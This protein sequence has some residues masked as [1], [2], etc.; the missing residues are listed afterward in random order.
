MK[1][2]FKFCFF[3]L[4]IAAIA[5]S[6]ALAQPI[7]IAGKI[8]DKLEKQPLRGCEVKLYIGEN[9]INALKIDNQSYT[10]S[11]DNLERNQNYRMEVTKPELETEIIKIN[12]ADK[13]DR[14]QLINITVTMGTNVK[15]FVFDGLLLDRDTKKP[16]TEPINIEV[17]NMQTNEISYNKSTNVGSYSLDIRQ[18]YEYEIGF[19]KNDYLKHRIKF[20]FCPSKL[21]SRTEFCISGLTNV[22]FKDGEDLGFESDIFIDKIEIDKTFVIDGNINFDYGSARLQPAGYETLKKVVLML[23]DNPQ[24]KIE[25]SAHTDSRGSDEFNM[26]LSKKRAEAAVSYII[27]QGIPTERIT[28]QGYGETQLTNECANGVTCPEY[29][30][31]ANRRAEFKITGIGPGNE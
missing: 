13:T 3:A 16:V 8:L 22:A 26:E 27:A 25:F 23:F 21:D 1:I 14:R 30:H 11:F 6:P 28:A 12:T 7:T 2:Y 17:R 9:L 15:N 29:K 5:S 31:A 4:I 19:Y 10:F 20:N 24:I 18:G